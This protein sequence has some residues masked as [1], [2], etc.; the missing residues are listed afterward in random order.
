MLEGINKEYNCFKQ[1]IGVYTNDNKVKP[2]DRV[3]LYVVK[4]IN[5]HQ[6]PLCGKHEKMNIYANVKL[7]CRKYFMVKRRQNEIR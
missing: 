6:V 1:N 3:G 5:L 2:V 4:G 7:E